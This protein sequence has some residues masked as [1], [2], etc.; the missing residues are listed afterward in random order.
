MTETT[1][2]TDWKAKLTTWLVQQPFP[3]V[4]VVA[5]TGLFFALGYYT[6]HDAMPAQL[7]AIQAGYERQEVYHE[8]GL[9]NLAAA[10]DRDRDMNRQILLSAIREAIDSR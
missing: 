6:I 2:A 1:A 7:K 5:H 3:V 8:R 10:I 9:N 4:L